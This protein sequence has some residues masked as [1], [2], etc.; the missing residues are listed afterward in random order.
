[1]LDVSLGKKF[2]PEKSDYSSMALWNICL[3]FSLEKKKEEKKETKDLK[4]YILKNKKQKK[5]KNKANKKKA[6]LA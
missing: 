6:T 3:E 2:D 4:I 1:M 5:S